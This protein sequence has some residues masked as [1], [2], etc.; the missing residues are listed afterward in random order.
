MAGSPFWD[1][2]HTAA[3]SSACPIGAKAR[4]RLASRAGL[5]LFV[6][7]TTAR[8]T[9]PYPDG[10]GWIIAGPWATAASRRPSSANDYMP[11]GAHPDGRDVVVMARRDVPQEPS[12]SL[13]TSG[14]GFARRSSL[15]PKSSHEIIAVFDVLSSLRCPLHQASPATTDR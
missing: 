11:F 12:T 14:S 4:P 2:I 3:P 10:N 8:N 5:A 1:P 9:N 15:T 7:P 13:D 6:E